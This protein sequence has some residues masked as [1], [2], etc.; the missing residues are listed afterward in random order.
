[1]AWTLS[2]APISYNGDFS[3]LF[4]QE[5]Q[6][7]RGWEWMGLG[8]PCLA[9]SAF[10]KQSCYFSIKLNVALETV[11]NYFNFFH[12]S[13]TSSKG[14]H[15]EAERTGVISDLLTRALKPWLAPAVRYQPV[16]SP[17]YT[18]SLISSFIYLKELIFPL[19]CWQIQQAKVVFPFADECT[20]HWPFQNCSRNRR[21]TLSLCR[22]T[23][24][25]KGCGKNG[26]VK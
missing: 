12:M 16:F 26:R 1:M 11:T 10:D 8:P 13:F 25:Y 17:G 21:P 4:S 5:G 19:C 23:Y 15:G 2:H 18:T 24:F 22:W 3:N 7:Q 9:Q 14:N 20:N 6:E